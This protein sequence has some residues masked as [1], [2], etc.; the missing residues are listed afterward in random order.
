MISDLDGSLGS[1]YFLNVGNERTCF[2]SCACALKSSGLITCLEFTFEEKVTY[3]F[4]AFKEVAK[5]F[6]QYR[7]HFEVIYNILE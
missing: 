3:V 1:R 4:A 6:Y 2:A 7:D 5:R